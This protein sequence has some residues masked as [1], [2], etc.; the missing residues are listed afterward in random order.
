MTT[1]S[2]KK[3]KSIPAKP[4]RATKAKAAPKKM[5]RPSSFTQ[6]AG[7]AICD[8]VQAGMTWAQML[9]L[10]GMPDERTLRRWLAD[11]ALEDFRREYIQAREASAS[12]IEQQIIAEAAAAFDKDSAAVARVRVDALKWI[13]AKRAPKV[14][15]DKQQIELS[16]ELAVRQLSDDDLAAR[17]AELAAKA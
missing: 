6:A 12:A 1:N 5:G 3:S 9:A 14:Y 7:T 16:G 15:G 2:T 4:K 11:P 13:A 10:D 17:L 8:A